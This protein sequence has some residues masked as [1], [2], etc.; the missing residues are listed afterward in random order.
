MSKPPLD[1][2]VFPAFTASGLLCTVGGLM[3]GNAI[4]TE[5]CRSFGGSNPVFGMATLIY[6]VFV[7]QAWPHAAVSGRLNSL[8]ARAGG[9]LL[10]ILAAAILQPALYCAVKSGFGWYAAVGA[11]VVLWFAVLLFAHR[12]VAPFAE[13]LREASAVTGEGP[14]A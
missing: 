10:L 3:L 4:S 7:A 12:F 13:R 9:L 2:R 11:V 5:Q 1:N 8:A 14:Q 6:A